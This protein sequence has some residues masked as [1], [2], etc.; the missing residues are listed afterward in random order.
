MQ[1]GACAEWGRATPDG[2]VRGARFSIDMQPLTGLFSGAALFT[3]GSH[4]ISFWFNF[5]YRLFAKMTVGAMPRMT[6][7]LVL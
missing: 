3:V 7:E 2:V 6:Q 1:A 5:D 4:V